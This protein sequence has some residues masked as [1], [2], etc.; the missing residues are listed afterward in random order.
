MHRQTENRESNNNNHVPSCAFGLGS[1]Y[2]K[3]TTTSIC[4]TSLRLPS[5]RR[6]CWKKQSRDQILERESSSRIEHLEWERGGSNLFKLFSIMKTWSA[7]CPEHFTVYLITDCP[8]WCT[9]LICRRLSEQFKRS[10]FVAWALPRGWPQY[11]PPRRKKRIMISSRLPLQSPG[12]EVTIIIV[13]DA[14]GMRAQFDI[15]LGLIYANL[16]IILLEDRLPYHVI[17][18]MEFLDIFIVSRHPP[19]HP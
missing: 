11:R 3:A 14:N 15:T 5:L 2:H 9:L 16:V 7:W 8:L 10:L 1:H 18:S 6:R 13:G 12:N 19:K 4:A 17:Y